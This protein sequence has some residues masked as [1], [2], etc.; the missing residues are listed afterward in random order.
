MRQKV[1]KID[2]FQRLIDVTL[3]FSTWMISYFLK[4]EG[5]ELF[6]CALGIGIADKVFMMEYSVY[7]VISPESCAS[8]L[9]SDPKQAEFA[10]NSLQLG[11]NKAKELNIIDDIIKEPVGGAH[12]DIEKAFKTIEKVLEKQIEELSGKSPEDLM[13][14]RYEKF[15]VMGNQTISTLQDTPE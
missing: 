8:I 15:R 5:G 4:F 13:N 14:D 6:E 7:S 2:Y 10:A 12:K 1:K 11:P 3:V 9:W